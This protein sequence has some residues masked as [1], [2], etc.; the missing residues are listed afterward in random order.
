[1]IYDRQYDGCSH[2]HF[3]KRKWAD[4]FFPATVLNDTDLFLVCQFQTMAKLPEA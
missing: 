4:L 3:L 2:D 1:M